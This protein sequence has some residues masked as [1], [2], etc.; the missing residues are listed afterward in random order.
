MLL[1]PWASADHWPVTLF[2]LAILFTVTPPAS[3][4]SPPTYTS[5]PLTAMAFTPPS[6]PP[7]R[8]DHWPVRLFHLAMLLAGVVP[9]RVNAPPTYTS[10]PLKARALVRP[11]RPNAPNRLSQFSS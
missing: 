2:H 1:A 7:P 10:V 8:A 3:V 11:S 9:A 5:L 4:K 6:T